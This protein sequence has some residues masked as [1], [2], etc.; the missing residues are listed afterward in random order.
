[1]HDET[2]MCTILT[3]VCSLCRRVQIIE[4][5]SFARVEKQLH[6]VQ[7]LCDVLEALPVVESET[8]TPVIL[9]LASALHDIQTAAL[10][11]PTVLPGVYEVSHG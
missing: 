2:V 4:G 1:M 3:E 11:L 6:V 7:L 9:N 5:C 10:M 8:R